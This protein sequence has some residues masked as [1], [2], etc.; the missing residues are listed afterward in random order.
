MSGASTFTDATEEVREL[1]D[2]VVESAVER[3]RKPDPA[4]YQ[5]ACARLDVEPNRC[6]FLDDIGRNLKPAAAMGMQTI[7]VVSQDQ[8]IDDLSALTGLT[9][10]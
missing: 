7:K 10:A 8:A 1:F 9:F 3:L 4:I 5:L 2:V 6:I